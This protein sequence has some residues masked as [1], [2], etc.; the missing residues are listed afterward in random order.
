VVDD[1]PDHRFLTKRALTP[2]RVDVLMASGGEEALACV[3]APDAGARPE[4]VLLDVKMPGMDGFEVLRRLREERATR[5]LPVILFTSS[6]N[7]VDVERARALGA[8]GFVTKPLDARAF[9]DVVRSTVEG[10]ARQAR[11]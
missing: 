4:L 7:A 11:R 8:D 1:N 3:G 5:D 9:V 10:W 6:E 2:L